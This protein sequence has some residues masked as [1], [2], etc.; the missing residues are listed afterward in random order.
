MNERR[1]GFWAL[2]VACSLHPEQKSMVLLAQSRQ[3]GLL[4]E[5]S[6]SRETRLPHVFILCDMKLHGMQSHT[7]ELVLIW[8]LC[9]QRANENISLRKQTLLTIYLALSFTTQLTFTPRLR[10]SS[11]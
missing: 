9:T 1:V 11:V 2:V 7:D 6:G 8:L 3:T 5:S 4:S 10:T